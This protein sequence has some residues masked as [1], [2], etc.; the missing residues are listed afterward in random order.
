M[1]A[2]A[3]HDSDRIKASFPPPPPLEGTSGG[4]QRPAGP[5]PAQAGPP[6][7]PCPA[8]HTLRLTF[9]VS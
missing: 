2:I 1:S 6:R 3:S 5:S 9:L 7:A 4:H 8:A